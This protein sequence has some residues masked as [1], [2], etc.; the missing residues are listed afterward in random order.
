MCT[1]VSIVKHLVK[2]TKNMGLIQGRRYDHGVDIAKDSEVDSEIDAKAV[3]FLWGRVRGW[4]GLE[5]DSPFCEIRKTR[6][7]C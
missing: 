3:E 6:R 7:I 4:S 1:N 2:P 5:L